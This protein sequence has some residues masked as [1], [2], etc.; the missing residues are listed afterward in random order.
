MPLLDI[1]AVDGLNQ[2]FTVAICLLDQETRKD[3]KWAIKHLRKLFQPG[4]WPSVIVTDCEEALIQAVDKRFPLIR[5]KM[6]LCY[7]HASCNVVKR[8]K[9]Y[10]ETEERWEEFMKG[11]KRCVYAKTEEEFEDIVNE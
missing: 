5:T 4:I 6:I 8:C 1:L 3:Y 10:F 11:F 7:W 2:G 9:Q